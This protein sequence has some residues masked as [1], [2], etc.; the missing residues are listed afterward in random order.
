MSDDVPKAVDAAGGANAAKDGSVRHDRHAK[1]HARHGAAKDAKGAKDVK[2]AKAPRGTRRHGRRRQSSPE[3]RRRA[4]LI[5]TAAGC[6][7]VGA[8]LGYVNAPDVRVTGLGTTTIAET[9]SSHVLATWTEGAKSHDVTMGDYASWASVSATGGTYDVPGASSVVSYIQWQIELE[10]ADREGIEATD[11]D[12]ESY[13]KDQLGADSVS[14]LASNAGMGE[15]DVKDLIRD[16]VRISKLRDKVAGTVDVK[17][18]TAPDKPEDGNEDEATA[19]YA[20][21]ITDLAGDEWDSSANDGK[22]GWKD[23]SSAMAQA[24]SG[25]DVTNDSATYK[26]AQAAYQQRSSEYSTASQKVSDAWTD[27]LDGI[28]KDVTIDLRD[29]MV[30]KD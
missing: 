10:A 11:D 26:A 4:T 1:P 30:G 15:D 5:A 6:L 8:L 24:L 21:Y 7:V 9:D 16:N 22:G 14:S 29:A 3:H 2:D 17:S 23:G 19:D 27:Y 12:I 13:A 25:Y 20:K 18:P 28:L